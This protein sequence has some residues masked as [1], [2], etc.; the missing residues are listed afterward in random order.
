MTA[1]CANT[2]PQKNRPQA[3]QSRTPSPLP[4]SVTSVIH[5]LGP[6]TEFCVN[7]VGSG[8]PKM[9]ELNS[10]V[11][12]MVKRT[13]NPCSHVLPTTFRRVL[14]ARRRHWPGS[15]LRRG[16]VPGAGVKLGCMSPQLPCMHTYCCE[17]GRCQLACAQ[18][19]TLAGPIT[20]AP[21]GYA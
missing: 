19:A 12:R 15:R 5:S 10:P 17:K 13:Y 8:S 9:R 7:A 21:A 1:P 3:W 20:D 2:K 14:S 11:S 6:V 16:A 4:C 18:C